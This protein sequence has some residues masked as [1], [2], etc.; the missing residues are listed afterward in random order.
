MTLFSARTVCKTPTRKQQ[1]CVQIKSPMFV[2][3]AN[4]VNTLIC[5]L[6]H[7]KNC[8]SLQSETGSVTLPPITHINIATGKLPSFSKQR[9]RDR[10]RG[11]REREREREKTTIQ[12][13]TFLSKTSHF[14]LG[15]NMPVSDALCCHYRFQ[16]L[17]KINVKARKMRGKQ[18]S[19]R[20]NI[21][22]QQ[23]NSANRK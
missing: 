16:M 21:L 20:S 7:L 19:I 14:I 6:F 9:D 13:Y 17:K 23:L 4:E 10:D 3:R 1:V 11:E 12:F 5:S 18:L 8:I 2:C 22:Y 15:F